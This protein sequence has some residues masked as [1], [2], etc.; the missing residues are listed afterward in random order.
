M[1]VHRVGW[2]KSA[3]LGW[4]SYE[5]GSTVC[6]TWVTQQATVQEL[7]Y[8]M[9]AGTEGWNS[10]QLWCKAC[11]HVH[12]SAV[13]ASASLCG[14]RSAWWLQFKERLWTV[15]SLTPGS[16][17]GH[18]R[19]MTG[20]WQGINSEDFSFWFCQPFSDGSDQ[21]RSWIV[22]PRQDTPVV[23]YTLNDICNI[24]QKEKVS[25]GGRTVQL[26]SWMQTPEKWRTYTFWRRE[27]LR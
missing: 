7:G 13:S 12:L 14:R 22:N 10:I 11:R 3:H 20:L 17:L 25:S 8:V 4:H 27:I 16:C 21:I 24:L 5:M 2:N 1:P 26:S 15:L 6:M 9:K 18:D 23:G 19:L